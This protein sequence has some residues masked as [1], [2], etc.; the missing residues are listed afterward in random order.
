MG[1][2]KLYTKNDA[3]LEPNS[4]VVDGIWATVLLKAQP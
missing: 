4:D 2:K 1:T 3:A